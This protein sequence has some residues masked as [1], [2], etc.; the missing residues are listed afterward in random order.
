M[1]RRRIS[2]IRRVLVDLSRA[3]RDRQKMMHVKIRRIG[4]DITDVSHDAG[5]F[6]A[7]GF[8]ALVLRRGVIRCE[9][10]LDGTA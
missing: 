3:D 4:F 8:D 1:P 7:T 10:D 6:T 5:G 2:E 9:K